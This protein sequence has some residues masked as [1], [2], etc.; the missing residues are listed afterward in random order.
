MADA[1]YQPKVYRA[2]GGDSLVITSS[3]TLTL[4]GRMDVS[5]GSSITVASGGGLSLASGS[6]FSCATAMEIASG[7]VLKFVAGSE[8]TVP[9]QVVSSSDTTITNSG[10]SYITGTTVGPDYVMAAPTRSGLF[11]VLVLNASS[12]G[13]T[14]R[15]TIYTGSTGRLIVSTP[16]GASGNTITLNTSAQHNITLIAAGTS[17]WVATQAQIYKEPALSAKST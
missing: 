13:A 1:S 4:E 2:Q 6:S 8:M 14:H 10:Y 9:W 15:A 16:G 17:G 7:G 12:S 5:S 3:G 11:K